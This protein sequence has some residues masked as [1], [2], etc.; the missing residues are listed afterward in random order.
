MD[1]GR[2]NLNSKYPYI[3]PAQADV[4]PIR[5]EEPIEA[6][7]RSGSVKELVSHFN[8][9]GKGRR[10]PPKTLTP[11]TPTPEN[12][13][14]KRVTPTSPTSTRTLGSSPGFTFSRQLSSKASKI[15][16]PFAYKLTET[17]VAPSRSIPSYG[18][19]TVASEAK[20]R[21]RRTPVSE[22]GNL[23]S[24]EFGAN[25]SLIRD[26]STPKIQN[27]SSTRTRNKFKLI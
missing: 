17:T 6:A 7:T 19:H 13:D 8:S 20:I 16:N 26:V 12:L 23:N 3:N 22:K 27:P 25:F 11:S 24:M 21:N 14:Y 9:L 2:M 1:S 10:F 15:Q 5:E 4:N 18:K